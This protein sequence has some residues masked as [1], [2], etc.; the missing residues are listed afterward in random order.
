MHQYDFSQIP[1]V[2][3]HLLHPCYVKAKHPLLIIMLYLLIKANTMHIRATSN[4]QIEGCKFSNLY[5]SVSNLRDILKLD[6]SHSGLSQKLKVAI[7]P[8]PPL[9]Y[10]SYWCNITHY[11]NPNITLAPFLIGLAVSGWLRS[12]TL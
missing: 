4:I 6:G 1:W 12:Q 2:Q 3:L 11:T 7:A 9:Y 10:K 5:K 8:H